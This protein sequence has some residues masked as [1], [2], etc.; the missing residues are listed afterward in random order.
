MSLAP[1]TRLFAA[2][3]LPVAASVSFARYKS[4][5]TGANNDSA[6]QKQ[7]TTTD[8]QPSKTVNAP[9]TLTEAQPEGPVDH[10]TGPYSPVASF[11]QPR[12]VDDPVDAASLSGAPVDLQS[13]TVRIYKPTKPAT[14]SG[15]W[16]GR[17]WKMDWDVLG[18]GHRW[19]NQLMG[20]Q[21][22]GDSMQGTHIFFKT[23]EDAID[24]AERQGYDWFVQEPN[25]RVFRP[26]SYAANFLHSPKKLKVIHTK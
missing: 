17:Q 4:S 18:K 22:S 25:E 16:N 12:G 19:E 14:Q 26:K 24:F 23:K 7:P 10:S 13:R 8:E 5:T 1:I 15:N 3:R 2:R 20:W 21:S 9:G 11:P 6:D